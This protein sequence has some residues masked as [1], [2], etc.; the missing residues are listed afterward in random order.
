MYTVIPLIPLNKIFYLFSSC[1]IQVSIRYTLIVICS[2]VD[3]K[4]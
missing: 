4:Q 3:T 2:T 1:Q